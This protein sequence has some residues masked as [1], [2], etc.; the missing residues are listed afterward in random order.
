VNGIA[1]EADR[2]AERKVSRRR[3]VV[4]GRQHRHVVR[5]TPEEE[6]R[7]LAKALAHHISVPK[8]LVES[9]L[10]P[11]TGETLTERHAAIT[12]LFAVHRLL[13]AVSNNLNQI[14]RATNVTGEVH[15]EL[16]ATIAAVRKTSFR[17]DDVA[18]VLGAGQ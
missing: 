13:A 16:R 11:S 6:A 4:G 2:S 14:A 12:E 18:D 3:R 17:L 5:V 10:A 1:D 8:L 15:D 7:L 9:A